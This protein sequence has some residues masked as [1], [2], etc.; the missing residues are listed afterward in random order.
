VVLRQTWAR[1]LSILHRDDL[2]KEFDEEAQSHIGLAIEDYVKGGMP[3]AQAQR[4]A[5]INFGSVAASKDGQRDARGLAWLEGLLFDLRLSLRGLGRDRAFTLAAITMLTLAIALNVT[6][7]TVMDAMLFRGFPFVRQNDRLVYLQERFPS[8]LCCISYMD[9]EEWRE[10]AATFEGLAFV[11]ERQIT[12]RDGDG[13][14]MDTMAF[15]VS[16][17]A[18]ALLGVPPMLGRDFAPAD[19]APG[20]APVAIL[21]YRF[22]EKRF[23]K[24]AEI[25]G[26]TVYVN[27]SPATIIGVMPQGFDFPTKEDLWMPLVPSGELLQRGLTRGG[28]VAVGRLRDDASLSEAR[29]ELETI[30]RRLEAAFP[31]TNRG[32]VPTVATHS[33]TMSGRDAA[34]I[35]GSLFVGAWFVLLIACANL[36]NLTLVRTIG[37]WHE[38]ATRIALGAGQGRMIRQILMESLT[39]ASAAGVLG[40]LITNWSMRNWTATTESRYQVLDYA[41]DAGTRGYL[42]TI[43]IGAALLMSLPAIV[44]VVQLGVNGALKGDARG[45]T[46]SLRGKHLAAG[47]VAGQMALAIVLLSGA[48]VLV[49]SFVN[50]VGADSGV[51]DPESILVG[52]LRLPSD[53]YWNVDTRRGYYERVEARLKSIPGV[54]HESMASTIPVKTAGLQIFE[55]EGTMGAPNGDEAVAVLRAGPDYFHVLGASAISGRD[56][57]DGDHASGL[58]VTIVNAS[59]AARFWP[60]EEA[61]GKR[62]RLRGPNSS[63]QWRTIVGVVPAI[64]QN[65]PLRQEFKPVVYVPFQQ[66][67]ASRFAYFLLRTSLPPN[68]LAPAV[69]ADVHSV[70]P[71]VVLEDFGTL[72]ASFAFDRDFMDAAHSELGKH[73][74]VAPVF[75]VIALLLSAIGLSA[76]IAHSVSQRTK[77]IGVRMAIGAG[78]SDVRR[79]ILRE[80]MSPVAVGMMFGLAA[81]VAV[82]RILQSQLVG[83]SPYDLITLI[84]APALLSL[85]ALIA[86]QIPARRAMQVEPVVAL[87]HE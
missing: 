50:I 41:V 3:L 46:Q 74:K 45:V 18:F 60:G 51:R 9:F 19:G 63:D 35:W 5:R 23:G 70:D 87:R 28:F 2:D 47:L 38:F 66:E 32:V 15:T 78:A 75:A 13:R 26:S 11:G 22:W 7:F 57:N 65:D 73:A 10:Q 20:A 29:A 8:G 77:E 25:V 58:P 31:T 21:N 33:E 69:R 48:G 4:L 67:P 14:P 42:V 54:Q 27:G 64:L 86:C 49:R 16:A 71:D 72:Q 36:A 39:L 56:F 52:S 6:V 62:L 12:L 79:M 44:R 17:N 30:S 53:T 1:L 82:N 40:W 76:V 84:G 80:G 55:I 34:L 24:R 68:Q 37:R 83:V 81:A 61:V 59:F 43:C 85:V